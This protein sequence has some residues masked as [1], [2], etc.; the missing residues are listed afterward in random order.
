MAAKINWH[1][2]MEQNCVTITTC[3][4][5]TIHIASAIE[6][7]IICTETDNRNRRKKINPF[8]VD[9]RALCAGSDWIASSEY[10]FISFGQ[11]L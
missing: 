7:S 2:Y 9:L 4:Y 8:Y 11:F 10:E 3:I 5:D 1:S 6:R